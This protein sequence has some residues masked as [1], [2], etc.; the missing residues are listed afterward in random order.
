MQKAVVLCP[1]LTHSMSNPDISDSAM[2][3][4]FRFMCSFVLYFGR[5]MRLKHV[6]ATGK[7]S[8]VFN[9]IDFRAKRHSLPTA[10]VRHI[11]GQR[12]DIGASSPRNHE[13]MYHRVTGVPRSLQWEPVRSQCTIAAV[14]NAAR[15]SS[16]HSTRRTIQRGRAWRA[17]RSSHRGTLCATSSPLCQRDSSHTARLRAGS[18]DDELQTTHTDTHVQKE[19][20]KNNWG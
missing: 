9:G 17:V 8:S 11:H 5:S 18:T 1:A 20:E 14:W 6:W 4:S 2:Y 19:K 13:Q 10:T 3:S 7:S 15:L 12:T 16:P